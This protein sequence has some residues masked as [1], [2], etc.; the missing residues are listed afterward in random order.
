MACELG[1]QRPSF[2]GTLDHIIDGNQ[3]LCVICLE[4]IRDVGVATPC[5]HGNFDFLC[6]VNWL[7]Q[8]RV[9]PLCQAEVIAVKYD[10][11]LASTYLL[12]PLSNTL[13]PRLPQPQPPEDPL[14]RRRHV[15]QF[16]LYSR[17]VGTNALSQYREITPQSFDSD[18]NLVSRARKWI[19]RELKVFTFLG[20]E[21]QGPRQRTESNISVPN[22]PQRNFSTQNSEFLLEFIIAILRNIDIRGNGGQAHQILQEFLGKRNAQLFLH[23]LQAWLRSPFNLL[24]DWDMATQYD[25]IATPP[26]P[27]IHR[28]QH[29][30]NWGNSELA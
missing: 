15:Y 4:E 20:L 27:T 7:Q 23:E 19:R 18:E 2:H 22:A 29:C 6:L 25:E 9:C 16:T 14:V 10:F 24:Q 26:I 3:N 5:K 30:V 1:L 11:E 12:P 21:S 17:R 28:I 13:T 8:R